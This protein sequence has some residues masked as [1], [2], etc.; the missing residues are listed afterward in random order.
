MSGAVSE[1][2]IERK[3]V[4]ITSDEEVKRFLKEGEKL[5]D[6]GV[7]DSLGEKS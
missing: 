1:D 5:L 3:G 7:T 4:V 2:K 6:N